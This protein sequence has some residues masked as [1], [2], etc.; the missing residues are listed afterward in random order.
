[1]PLSQKEI[2]LAQLALL[3]LFERPPIELVDLDTWLA[4]Q[5]TALLRNIILDWLSEDR[6][7]PERHAL[8]AYLLWRVGLVGATE[9]LSIIAIDQTLSFP[10][11]AV[12]LS[13]LSEHDPDQSALVLE[14]LDPP[15]HLRLLTA[16]VDDLLNAAIETGEGDCVRRML[17]D[18][19][20]E[21]RQSLYDRTEARR[22]V[23]RYGHARKAK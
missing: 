6:I 5:P 14:I 20:K 10:S 13:M 11:R 9:Q 15:D 8:C 22:Q 2:R 7:P 4:G 1:M 17:S 3:E 18:L 16:P 21:A 23:E 19:P 12:A